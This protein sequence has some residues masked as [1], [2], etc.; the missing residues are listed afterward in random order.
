MRF[1]VMVHGAK[2]I[3]RSKN[4]GLGDNSMRKR[5]QKDLQGNCCPFCRFAF[6][7][8]RFSMLVG[9]QLETRVVS[10]DACAL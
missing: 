9:R 4:W 5:L 3:A 1:C 6:Q 7:Q 8:G 10:G 2:A